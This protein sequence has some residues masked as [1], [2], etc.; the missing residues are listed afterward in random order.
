MKSTDWPQ[1]DYEENIEEAAKGLEK[2]Y[3]E[4]E[5]EEK[6]EG[7]EKQDS[8]PYKVIIQDFFKN[9][10]S[11][12]KYKKY[13]KDSMLTL[14]IDRISEEVTHQKGVYLPVG[15]NLIRSLYKAKNVEDILT[16]MNEYL[17]S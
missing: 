14:V 8:N 15:K 5:M 17:F 11:G 1:E 4:N 2:L 10:F 12:T 9:E 16:K 6:M 13:T 7:E 3:Y